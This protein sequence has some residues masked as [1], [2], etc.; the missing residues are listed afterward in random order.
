MDH[1]AL[2]RGVAP[3]RAYALMPARQTPSPWSQISER[4]LPKS[5]T[6]LRTGRKFD[7]PVLLNLV[8]A[9]AHL[10]KVVEDNTIQ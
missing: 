2:H 1:S 3:V 7:S 6:K 10:R 9:I 8:R 4:K 5:E